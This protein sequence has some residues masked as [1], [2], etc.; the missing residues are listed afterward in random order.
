VFVD[1]VG[2]IWMEKPPPMNC[3]LL[4]TVADPATGC[5]VDIGTLVKKLAGGRPT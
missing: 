2:I 4:G 5:K 3:T 1:Y